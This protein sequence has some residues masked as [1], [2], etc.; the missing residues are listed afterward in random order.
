MRAVEEIAAYAHEVAA[1]FGVEGLA[2]RVGV[3]TGPAVVGA[4]GAGSRVEYS[5]LG[6]AVNV[7]ARLQSHAEPGSVLVGEQTQRRVAPVFEWGGP[8]ALE[9]K[10]KDAPVTAFAV[11]SASAHPGTLRG[12][13]GVQARLVGRDRELALGAEVVDSVLA[14]S[15]GILVVSGEPG[16]GKTRLVAE[17]R[18]RFEAAVPE[19]GRALWLEGRCVS[20]GESM[21]YWPF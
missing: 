17:L 11:S 19:H 13:E 7:A 8:R 16:I 4:I 9:L 21:P 3:N 20:Y 18:E 6:D 10:G 5:A 12:L 2:L 14:G 15:G 1:A